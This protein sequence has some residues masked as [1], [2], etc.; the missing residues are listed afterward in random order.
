MTVLPLW[1][2]RS[3]IPHGK[4]HHDLAQTAPTRSRSDGGSS[5]SQPPV[6]VLV[7]LTIGLSRWSRSCRPW[8]RT[9][10]VLAA[11]YSAGKLLLINLASA[12]PLACPGVPVR[13]ELSSSTP[14]FKWRQLAPP[15]LLRPSPLFPSPPF[16][17]WIFGWL[18]LQGHPPGDHLRRGTMLC[19]LDPRSQRMDGALES[20]LNP[21]TA[22]VLSF[23]GGAGFLPIPSGVYLS[24]YSNVITSAW[25]VARP[26]IAIW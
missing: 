2:Y 19:R 22:R 14:A 18:P 6:T 9:G 7:P 1:A 11:S 20:P 5:A 23:G 3:P 24:E 15:W 10:R 4:S 8:H 21:E 12:S 13:Y 17:G 16:L 26:G 25:L